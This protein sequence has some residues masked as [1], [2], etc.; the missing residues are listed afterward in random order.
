MALW[1]SLLYAVVGAAWI[2][3]S[4]EIL[5]AVVTNEES[6]HRLEIYKGWAFIGTT[7]ILLFVILRQQLRRWEREAAARREAEEALN[8]SQERYQ[9]IV[10]SLRDVVFQSDPEGHWTFLNR[11]WEQITGFKISETL[12]KFYLDFV[13]PED[14]EENARLVQELVDRKRAHC[15]HYVRY[16]HQQ[17]G[18]RWVEIHA[19][20]MFD[21]H[22]RTLGMAGTLRDISERRCAEERLRKSEEHLQHAAKVGGVG[23]FE[24]NH[25]TDEIY[26]SPLLRQI[27]GFSPDQPVTN[28]SLLKRVVDEDRPALMEAIARAHDPSGSGRFVHE[29]RIIACDGR[30]HWLRSV[31]QTFFEGE[32]K[33]R[34]PLRTVGAVVDITERKLAEEAVKQSEQHLEI[35]IEAAGLGTWEVSLPD[36]QV[37]WSESYGDLFGISPSKF[38]TTEENLFCHVHP[39]DRDRVR[40]EFRHALENGTP[41]DCEFRILNAQGDVRWHAA[42][43]KAV[44]NQEGKPVRFAGVGMDIT[45][46]KQAEEERL[47]LEAQLRQAQKMEAIGT[48][49]GGVA[50]DFNNI[51]TVIHGNAS[52]LV[53]GQMSAA[54][55]NESARQIVRAAERAASLTRQLLMFS[56][57]QVMQLSNLS[58]NEVVAQM[59]KML[60]RI[61][62]E[63]I[64]LQTNFAPQPGVIRADAGMIEQILLNLAVNSRDAMPRGGKLVIATGTETLDKKVAAQ[65]PDALPGFHVWLSVTD[66]GCGIPPETLPRIFEPFFTTKEVGKGTGL[67]LAT[68][69]GIVKQHRGWITVSSHVNQ[70]TS[71]RIHF[72]ALPG[73]NFEKKVIPAPAP[74]PH[75]TETILIVEDDAAVRSLM[76]SLLKRCGY[77]V[78]EAQSGSAAV[79][80][81]KEVRNDVDL[82]LTDMVMPDGMT[83]LQLAEELKRDKPGLRVIY[84]TG[85]SNELAGKNTSLIEGVNFLQKPFSPESLARALRIML[86]KI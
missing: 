38:P 66:T 31:S 35:A 3:L 13:H 4:D 44:L 10:D 65:H 50:H 49:A 55:N 23:T 8:Q 72:P 37:K 5:H 27:Y 85:Y 18:F 80:L 15:Q 9:S 43:G 82:L 60:Q 7:A 62:G 16:L 17:G 75:G 69:Y 74:L 29:Q 68:V 24:H 51:L 14:R 77:H 81:W 42:M 45:E 33:L 57:K 54:D 30:V 79:R 76:I 21:E 63:D 58:L 25:V 19:E 61:L 28:D 34:W 84:V 6:Q 1:T 47:A 26:F 70:G 52:L 41:Y 20:L 73:A 67:G 2:L 71:V 39:D 11:A 59:T 56:R 83:G 64:A 46:R 53:N 36:M 22:Q 32:G 86:T 48:L 40:R 12:G 78:L